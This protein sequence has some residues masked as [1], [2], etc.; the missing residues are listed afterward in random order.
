MRN[1]PVP[2]TRV[3]PG[4]TGIAGPMPLIDPSV[5]TTVAD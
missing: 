5:I 2:S 3:A 4:G 1:L